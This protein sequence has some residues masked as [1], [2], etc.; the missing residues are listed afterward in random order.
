MPTDDTVCLENILE[1]QNIH[2][3]RQC[4][5][6]SVFNYLMVGAPW[7]VVSCELQ[8]VIAPSEAEET[9]REYFARTPLL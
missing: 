3:W 7:S 9:E 1:T 4:S 8:T 5:T 2:G 6:P